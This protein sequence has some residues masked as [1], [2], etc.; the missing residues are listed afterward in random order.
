[1][2]SWNDDSEIIKILRECSWLLE[3]CALAQCFACLAPD[4]KT[5]A[6]CSFPFSQARIAR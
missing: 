1:M 4:W 5:L 6:R 3:F 2:Y